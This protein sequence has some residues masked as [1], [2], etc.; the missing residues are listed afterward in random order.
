VF[1][2]GETSWGRS[3]LVKGFPF[4]PPRPPPLAEPECSSFF[5]PHPTSLTGSGHQPKLLQLIKNC[6]PPFEPP[7][8][9]FGS[10][11]RTFPLPCCVLAST[12]FSFKVMQQIFPFPPPLTESFFLASRSPALYCNSPWGPSI[13]RNGVLVFRE[14]G[15][16]GSF[17]RSCKGGLP[18]ALL[19]FWCP[20]EARER[21]FVKAVFS[22]SRTFPYFFGGTFF[23]MVFP[24]FFCMVVALLFFLLR[25]RFSL[26]MPMSTIVTRF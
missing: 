13:L 2:L 24:D 16:L 8:R 7:T 15:D 21:I 22:D 25:G 12:P 1:F 9:F 18:C 4:P 26:E 17:F 10:S 23:T 19:P 5:V 3:P 6:P 11:F 20:R 14:D